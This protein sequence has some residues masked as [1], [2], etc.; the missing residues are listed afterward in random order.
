M[1]KRGIISFCFLASLLLGCAKSNPTNPFVFSDDPD[2]P[3]I[4]RQGENLNKKGLDYGIEELTRPFSF[5]SAKRCIEE[6]RPF[7]L[8]LFQDGCSSCAAVH[9]DIVSFLL[10]SDIDIFGVYFKKGQHD[11]TLSEINQLK[12]AYPGLAS[13]LPSNLTTPTCYLIKDEISGYEM[14]FSAHRG[15]LSELEDYFASLLNITFIHHFVTFDSYS[16]FASKDDYLTIL[17]DDSS[18]YIDNI[19]PLAIH[20]EKPLIHIEYNSMSETDQTKL[21]DSLSL[22]TASSICYKGTSFDYS[23]KKDEA[24]NLA[25]SYYA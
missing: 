7:I 16:R 11:A 21:K 13:V 5:V 14:V 12:N 1:A 24:I 2:L 6:K 22:S 19:R 15:S 20:S 10:D 8:Y 17:D 23:N 4:D 18:F 9:D 25:Q 3:Y